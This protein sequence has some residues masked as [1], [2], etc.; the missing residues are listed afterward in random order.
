MLN[1]ERILHDFR[2]LPLELPGWDKE[3][4]RR[5]LAEQ[6]LGKR[7]RVMSE[8]DWQGGAR[9]LAWELPSACEDFPAP[10][11]RGLS[12]LCALLDAMRDDL[13]AAAGKLGERIASLAARLGCE[14][15]E[16]V[17]WPY[18]PYPGMLALDHTQAPIFFGRRAET[19]ALLAKLDSDQGRR[20]LLVAG[21]S[22]SGKSSLVRAGLWATLQDADATLI[23]GSSDWVITA[24]KPSQPANDPY[25]ALIWSLAKAQIPGFDEPDRGEADAL[26]GDAGAFALKD[27]Y[28]QCRGKGHMGL[29]DYL[30]ER[31]GGLSGVIAKR[32]GEAVKRAGV[33]TD[34]VLPRVFSRLLTVQADG[35]ATRRRE[36]LDHWDGDPDALKLIDALASRRTR[37]WS[38]PPRTSPRRNPTRLR[39]RYPASSAARS[40][41]PTRPCSAPGRT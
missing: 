20:L 24:M 29:D 25:Q 38:S 13:G 19:E 39:R 1:D 40:R 7:H 11:R 14:T 34:T 5:C 31:I 36:D 6:A 32:A 9:Q 26:R 18:D 16:Q 4:R 28:A 23:A 30:G 33:E 8:V 41:S 12:P 10:T 22:G 35:A 37:L 15:P 21:A 2:D 27:L 17:D 3:R